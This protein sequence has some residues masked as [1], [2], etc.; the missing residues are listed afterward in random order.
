MCLEQNLQ[1]Y[2]NKLKKR[3]PKN[4]VIEK[5]TDKNIQIAND[6]LKKQDKKKLEF[7]F[8]P[9]VSHFGNN[10]NYEDFPLGYI[11]R[12]T[13]NNS[14]IGFLGTICSKRQ[15]NNVEVVCCNL[16]HWYVEK[17][18]R[19]YGYAFFFPLLEK[20]IILNATTPRNS[21][22][23]L[24]KKFNFEIKVTKYTA[25]LG[26]NINS[27]FSKDYKRFT[28][29]S[30]EEE[31]NNTLDY[32]DKKIYQ[33]HKNYNCLNFV[34]I[35]KKKKLE[36]CFF[37]TKKN[38]R[39]YMTVL[40]IVY[41]SNFKQYKEYAPE[42]FTN[43]SLKYKILFIGQRY[44]NNFEKFQNN[45]NFLTKTKDKFFVIKT[46]NNHYI[47]DVLYSDLVMF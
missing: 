31:I 14:I 47:S 9:L 37:V 19:I 4:L 15:L 3:V 24:Y 17:E 29:I 45:P 18:F 33:D 28:I 11:M 38:I 10:W 39:Y 8:S 26:I 32:S 42:I 27:L 35:D 6:Y 7:K 41:A 44:F 1:E 40:D 22:I 5:V 2:I 12:N 36:P 34:I 16:V 20:K 43:I 13:N 23:G 46:Y 25:G 30:K 21:I